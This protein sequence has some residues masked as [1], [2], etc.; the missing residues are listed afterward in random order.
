MTRLDGGVALWSA[1]FVSG[2]MLSL[3]VLSTRKRDASVVDP[4]WGP[5]FLGIAVVALLASGSAPTRARL[6][7]ALVAVWALRLGIH[8]AWRARGAAEDPRYAAMRRRHGERFAWVSL[9]SVFGLQGALMWIVSLPL[10]LVPSAGTGWSWTAVLGAALWAVGMFFEVVGDAQ[11]TRF[12][13]DP[14]N[15]GRVLDTGLWRYTRHPNYFGEFLIWWGIWLATLS[16]PDRLWSALSP[17]LMSYLLLRVSGVP[18]L[19]RGLARTRGGYADYVARTPA[20]FPGRPRPRSG[21][22]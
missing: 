4:A 9:F 12:R 22:P 1:L 21:S 10:Q 3:W 6:A 15:A 8:L 7:T 13:A 11:L 2:Y 18:L 16:G 19:E 14:A 20:F 5:G 17:V